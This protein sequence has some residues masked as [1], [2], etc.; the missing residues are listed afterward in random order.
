MQ[1]LRENDKEMKWRKRSDSERILGLEMK[2]ED[3]DK[4]SENEKEKATN[5][6]RF[7]IVKVT[8]NIQVL[9]AV[10]NSLRRYLWLW[11]C[12]TAVVSGNHAIKG[13]VHRRYGQHCQTF[14]G[15]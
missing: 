11:E 7:V 8:V 13:T 15:C 14:N 6:R 12:D 10:T 5:G 1:K 4:K 9:P 2:T 3:C